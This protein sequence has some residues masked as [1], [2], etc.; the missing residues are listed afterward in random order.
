MHISQVKENNDEADSP[1]FEDSGKTV[2]DES[3]GN[4]FY[5]KYLADVSSFYLT[6]V[7]YMKVVSSV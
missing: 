2:V 3:Q 7:N 1:L 4:Y 5:D 6:H